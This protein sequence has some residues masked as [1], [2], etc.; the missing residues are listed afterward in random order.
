MR[1]VVNQLPALGQKTGI[2]HYTVQLL[3]CLRAQAGTDRID[4]FPEGW[5]RRVRTFCAQARPY[6]EGTRTESF[7]RSPSARRGGSLRSKALGSLRRLGRSLMAQH[8]RLVCALRSY[9][10]YHEPNFIP[11]P[12]E[13]PTLATLHD[14]S[15]VLHPEWHPA[16]RAAYFEAHFHQSLARCVHFLAISEFGRQ[17]MIRNLGIPPERITRTYMGIRPGLGPLPAETTARLLRELELPP[18]YLLYLGTIEPRKNI[19]VLLQAY[20][21]LPAKL[22][23]RW[24]LL[25]VGG[26]GWNTLAVADFLH[27][28]ARHRGVMHRGYVPEEHLAAIYNGA[29][30]LVYP[31]LYEGFG[32]P[33]VEMMACGGAVLA[34]TAGAL[35]ETI[36]SMA[37]LID[38]CDTVG[39]R[40]A[41]VRVLEDDDWWQSLRTGTMAVARTYTWDRCAAD[42]L[43]VY[44]SVCGVEDAE[45]VVYNP[46]TRKQY[47]Q[48]G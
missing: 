44:R 33:P 32:L 48:A 26:W 40:D 18:Q 41:M 42:T 9:D 2:G 45:A 7:P 38:P 11:L 12:C 23:A 17:E 19:L 25:L 15:V 47:R 34:S 29:R 46:A 6:L 37:H 24:P 30:A 3:R 22:R 21:A 1:V 43:R 36:G 31:S 5:V 20:C 4:G 27:R 28:E 16:D 39:W 8:F 35:V 13:Q 14:L 10:L